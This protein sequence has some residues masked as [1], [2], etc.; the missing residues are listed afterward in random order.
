M[1]GYYHTEKEGLKEAYFERGAITFDVNNN[2]EGTT[3]WHLVREG[4]RDN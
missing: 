2:P 1:A 3:L 4:K